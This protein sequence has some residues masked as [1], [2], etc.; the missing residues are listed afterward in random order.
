VWKK[1]EFSVA[2]FLNLWYDNAIKQGKP[3]KL[4]WGLEEYHGNQSD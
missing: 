2:S 3:V 4:L 1:P